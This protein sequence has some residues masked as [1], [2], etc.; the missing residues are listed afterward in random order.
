MANDNDLIR[1]IL[2]DK[3]KKAVDGVIACQQSEIIRKQAYYRDVLHN[4]QLLKYIECPKE[5]EMEIMREAGAKF[6]G[7]GT[8]R[9]AYR[10]DNCVVKVA[11][12]PYSKAE[13]ISEYEQYKHMTPGERQYFVPAEE[14]GHEG[15][16]ITMPY[17]Q[18]KT[19]GERRDAVIRMNHDLINDGI[20][21]ADMHESNIGFINGKPKIIDYA[22][23][24]ITPIIMSRRQIK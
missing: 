7:A 11:N 19:I 5:I 17:A 12:S 24:N 21:V 14:I 4:T 6:V 18:K 23:M 20:V 3:I 2:P 1:C 9:D 13:N 8:S 16:Y 10:W 22:N 15:S